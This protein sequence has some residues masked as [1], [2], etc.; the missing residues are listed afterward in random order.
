[1]VL[2][3]GALNL[4]A[5]LLVLRVRPVGALLGM[6]VCAVHLASLA[7]GWSAIGHWLVRG[8]IGRR[9]HLGQPQHFDQYEA[10]RSAAPMIFLGMLVASILWLF[11]V[12]QRTSG[13]HDENRTP[14]PT[15]RVH[16]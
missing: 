15:P 16:R 3:L 9:E 1:M 8:V 12:Y 5:G 10:I 13:P 11:I 7:L 4:A 2:A 14:S 6:A